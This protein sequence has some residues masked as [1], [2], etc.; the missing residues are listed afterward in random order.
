[1][2]IASVKKRL[3]EKEAQFT[4]RNPRAVDV[5]KE[6][7]EGNYNKVVGVREEEDS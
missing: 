6:E 1:V 7:I 2:K 3:A 5:W 4:A